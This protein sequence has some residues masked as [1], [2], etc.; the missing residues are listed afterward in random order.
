MSTIGFNGNVA[1]KPFAKRGAQVQVTKGVGY[2]DTKLALEGL[3]VVF[4][5][6]KDIQPGDTVWVAPEGMASWGKKEFEVL[7][8]KV[9]LCEPRY[10]LLV[11]KVAYSGRAAVPG[12]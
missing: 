6:G 1:C 3:T 5:D 12:Y 7:G 9:V 11:T 10:I 4:G 8:E 2:I